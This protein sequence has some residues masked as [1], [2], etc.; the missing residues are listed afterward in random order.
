MI[1]TLTFINS[2]HTWYVILG[3][4][5][6]LGFCIF[7]EYHHKPAR[8]F[9]IRMLVSLLAVTMLVLI[10][11]RPA[12]LMPY[13]EAY[14]AVLTKGYDQKQLDSLQ[15]VHPRLKIIKYDVNHPVLDDQVAMDSVFI[16]GYGIAPFDFWR[17]DDATVSFMGGQDLQG[18]TSF[19]YDA[20]QK[21]GAESI[22]KGKYSKPTKGHQLF[23]EGPWGSIIDSILLNDLDTQEFQFKMK[24][25]VKGRYLFSLIEKDTTGYVISKDPVPLVIEAP[26]SFHILIVNRF[27]TF[28]TKYLKNFLAES[29]HQVSVKSQIT[30]GRYKFEFFNTEKKS[31]GNFSEQLLKP[32]DLLIIDAATLQNLGERSLQ[33]IKNAIRNQGLGLFIQP[34]RN[35]YNIPLNPLTFNFDEDKKTTVQLKTEPKIEVSKYKYVFTNSFRNQVIHKDV[36]NLTITAYKQIGK[37]RI[38]TTILENTYELLLKGETVAYQNIWS[39]SI[40]EVSKREASLAKFEDIKRVARKNHP[41]DFTMRT[42]TEEPVVEINSNYQVPLRQNI[43][44]PEVYTGITYP[45]ASGWNTLSIKQDTTIVSHFFVTDSSYWQASRSKQRL[46]ENKRQFNSSSQVLTNKKYSVKPVNTLPLFVVFLLS[47]GYLWLAPKI[48]SD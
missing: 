38:A 28:E 2:Q 30:K 25:R 19:L 33:S 10:A 40:E 46:Q 27:P 48:A 45:I 39:R 6:L 23:F 13:V 37:G 32:F 26:I 4:C 31:I 18:V 9:W 3:G 7:K 36:Q 41:V 17:F 8:T 20:K 22:F 15:S 12:V 44:I 29:G 43:D 42:S 1:D 16:L 24:P 47:V 34:N 5:L 14:V 11:L 21:V 35:F